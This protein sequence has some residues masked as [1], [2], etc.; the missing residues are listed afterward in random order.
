MKHPSLVWNADGEIVAIGYFDREGKLIL[1]DDSI[2]FME[3]YER[4][5]G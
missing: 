1:V 2:G 5:F 3:R 4:Y